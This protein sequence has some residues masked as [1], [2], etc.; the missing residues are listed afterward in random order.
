MTIDYTAWRFWFDI[1][2]LG[3][4]CVLGGYSWWANREKVNAKRFASLEEE[5]RSRV[6]SEAL[7]VIHKERDAL[8][9]KHQVRTE[10]LETTLRGAPTRSEIS[11]LTH[12][13]SV[14]TSKLGRLEGRLDGLNRVADLINEFLI[15]QGSKR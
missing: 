7:K 14:L 12:E 4:L 15:N 5:V 1:L 3:G 2:Q 11:N 10:A 6:T 13:I 8:C 9:S